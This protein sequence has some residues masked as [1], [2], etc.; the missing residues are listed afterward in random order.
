MLF[1]EGPL[2]RLELVFLQHASFPP[3][4]DE[5]EAVTHQLNEGRRDG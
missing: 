4:F 5:A 3:G 1:I 2:K